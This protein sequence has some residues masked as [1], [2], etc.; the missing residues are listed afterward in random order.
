MLVNWGCSQSHFSIIDLTNSE[1][2]AKHLKT[3]TCRVAIFGLRW[4]LGDLRSQ[5]CP[6]G[7]QGSLK[8]AQSSHLG[9]KLGLLGAYG[10]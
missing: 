1:T 4:P 7:A 10:G 3:P 9:G 2:H 5:G 6:S 8:G